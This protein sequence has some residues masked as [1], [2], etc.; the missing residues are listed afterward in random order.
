MYTLTIKAVK[1]I[2]G[3]ERYKYFKKRTFIREMNG[4]VDWDFFLMVSKKLKM[5]EVK[6]FDN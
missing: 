1:Q 5:P 6:G 4:K 2:L 3:E